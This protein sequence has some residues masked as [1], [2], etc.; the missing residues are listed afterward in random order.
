VSADPQAPQRATAIT[1]GHSLIT[2]PLAFLPLAMAL[3]L[4]A[5]ARW[6]R[7]QEH[8]ATMIAAQPAT[9]IAVVTATTPSPVPAAV[10]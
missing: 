10:E 3:A 4:T 6:C 9:A 7:W 5:L 8:R 2:V 1:V